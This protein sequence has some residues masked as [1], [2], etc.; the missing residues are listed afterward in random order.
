M[1]YWARLY[2]SH[3]RLSNELRIQFEAKDPTT[4]LITG[5]MELRLHTDWANFSAQ[6]LR[7]TFA[8]EL[9][10]FVGMDNLNPAHCAVDDAVMQDQFNCE[11]ATVLNQ[12]NLNDTLPVNNTVYGGKTK[13]ACGW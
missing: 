12:P 2:F 5:N 10:H 3:D 13:A 6:G 7:R 9:G 1:W 11:S 4:G 8:H